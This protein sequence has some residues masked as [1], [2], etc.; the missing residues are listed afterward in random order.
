[1]VWRCP[2]NRKAS[3]KIHTLLERKSLERSESLIVVHCQNGIE[4][5][6]ISKSEESVRRIR[7]ECED[8]LSI[9][10]LHCRKDDG[11]FL[12]TEKSSVT[13]VRI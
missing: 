13:A 9:C 4:L 6:V 7:A 2:D 8:A 3:C 12:V 1:M 5:R 10:L 11:L